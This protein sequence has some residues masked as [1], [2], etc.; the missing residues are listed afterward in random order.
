MTG[1]MNGRTTELGE[2]HQADHQVQQQESGFPARGFPIGPPKTAQATLMQS[3]GDGFSL[4]WGAVLHPVPREDRGR[5]CACSRTSVT[6]AGRNRPFRLRPR[7]CGDDHRL[8]LT[9]AARRSISSGSSAGRCPR[10]WR[11][12]SAHVPGGP[13]KLSNRRPWRST[14]IVTSAVGGVRAP[15]CSGIRTE[16]ERRS[17]RSRGVC[18]KPAASERPKEGKFARA[19]AMVEQGSARYPIEIEHRLQRALPGTSV[20]GAVSMEALLIERLSQNCGIGDGA[21]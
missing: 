1:V 9:R 19:G 21:G 5:S 2:T 10:P 17:I 3:K 18:Q 14:G 13:A 16:P 11:W 8:P 7:L 6:F 15:L 12:G 4:P 20:C